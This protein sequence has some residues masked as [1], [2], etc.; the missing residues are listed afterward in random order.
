L[1]F[2]YSTLFNMENLMARVTLNPAVSQG[3]PTLRNMR[4]TVAQLL[5]LLAAGM[6]H[7]EILTDYP[8]LEEGDIRAALLYA[9][10]IANARFIVSLPVAAC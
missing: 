8:Y 1:V 2:S 6:T 10:H 7:E 5:E 4:F 3:K 9:A